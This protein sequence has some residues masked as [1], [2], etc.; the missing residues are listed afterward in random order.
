MRIAL[1][2]EYDGAGFSGWQRQSH[3]PSAQAALETALSQV[4]D[5]P[6]QVVCAGRT[7]A[8]VHALGQVV[9]FDTAVER[10]RR[11]W[12]LG[13]NSNLPAEISIRWAEA[14]SDEFHARY[15]ATAR[16]YRYVILNR[17]VRSALQR[18][19]AAWIHSPLDAERMHSAAQYLVGEH[20]FSAFRAAGC[21]AKTPNREIFSIVVRRDDEHVIIDVRGN[22]FLQHMVRNIAGVL[23]AVGSGDRE[24][25]W[26]KTVLD[27]RDRCAGGIT[28]PAH[29]LTFMQVE[30]PRLFA[31]PD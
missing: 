24:P 20:D 26:A 30:Y 4:A 1:G 16:V 17:P 8:G 10:S 21:Q 19:Y 31:L 23:I 13:G 22:A 9:H 12:V 18:L 15:S 11:A 7:D 29:G 2:I 28:A 27:G 3:V 25:V 5:E 6:L 14:V